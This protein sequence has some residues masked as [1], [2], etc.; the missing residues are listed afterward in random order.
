MRRGFL[1]SQFA[2]ARRWWAELWPG[3]RGRTFPF[4]YSVPGRTPSPP[5]LGWI[6]FSLV[7]FSGW[8][9]GGRCWPAYLFGAL[10]TL[11]FTFQILGFGVPTDFLA[12][13]PFI[14]TILVLA[15][16]S[17]R[18]EAARRLGAAGRLG[19]TFC[20]REPVGEWCHGSGNDQKD[21]RLCGY[22]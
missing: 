9:R 19:Q 10:T 18:P 13:L 15:L 12:M 11:G 5:G 4:R 20:E 14:M 7:I 21:R 8:R 6:A 3:W 17:S 16:I 22:D 1:L 2:T